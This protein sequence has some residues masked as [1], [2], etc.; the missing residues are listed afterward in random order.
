[1]QVSFIIINYNTDSLMLQAVDS[2]FKYVKDILFE[3]IVIDNNSKET[4][5]ANALA[6]YPNT[7]FYKFEKNVGF[8]KANNYGYKKS[9][10]Q[11]VFLL[12]S[13]AFLISESSIPTFIDY[14]DKNQKVGCVGG[15]LITEEGKPNLCYGNFLS[16]KKVLHDFGLKKV[17][18]NYYKN[19][20][21]T[22][23][24]CDFDEAQVVDYLTA[25]AIMIKRELIEQLGLFDERYFMYFEDMDLCF[26][27]RKKGFSSVLL[28]DVKIVHIGGQSG[29]NAVE[30]NSFLNKEIQRSKKIFLFNVANHTTVNMLFL[31]GKLATFFRRLKRKLKS[32]LNA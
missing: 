3:I 24:T 1:M 21:A 7:Y 27:Y 30:D 26:R 9:R 16:V 6:S 11:Y 22:S 13:D 20:L 5:L 25:A 17:D 23:K 14:L 4:K 2:V 12:N 15:N 19:H 31:L 32:I 10:G 8:S 29:L 18:A 28:P